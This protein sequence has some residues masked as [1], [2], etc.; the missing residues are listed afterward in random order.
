MTRLRSLRLFVLF[1]CL[2]TAFPA[3]AAAQSVFDGT[4]EYVQPGW[5]GKLLVEGAPNGAIYFRLTTANGPFG[6]EVVG[7]GQRSGD[8]FVYTDGTTGGALKVRFF[9]TNAQVETHAAL[10]G[11]CVGAAQLAG[12]YIK[13]HSDVRLDR[14]TVRTA[15][16]RLYQR[17]L[18][19]GPIDGVVGPRTREAVRQF[20]QRVDLPA[21]G[22]LTLQ[23]LAQLTDALDHTGRSAVGGLQGGA[24]AS[25]RVPTL[26]WAA[27]VPS[28]YVGWL[29]AL[30]A[31]DVQPARID[32][33]NPPFEI[34]LVDLDQT[35]PTTGQ[36]TPEIIV[37]WNDRA[38]CDASGCRLDVLRYDGAAYS[39]VL[40]DR[41]N[42]VALGRGFSRG[43]RDLILDETRTARWDGLAYTAPG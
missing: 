40:R 39:R 20:Q 18:P 23:T 43:M 31:R 1:A 24:T 36:A 9:S 29:D 11:G 14:E 27:S 15:Q 4:Y 12:V 10:P 8:G 37:F 34:A 33:A 13:V 19:V 28:A 21:D 6:C 41:A 22:A 17:G 30:Y 5:R 26:N 7:R 16:Y 3:V 42:S 25:V 38:F 32:Y 35:A 2:A